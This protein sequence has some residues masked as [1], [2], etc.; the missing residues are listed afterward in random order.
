MYDLAWMAD[1]SA[2]LGLLT[3]VVMEIVLG[4]DNLVFIAILASK[5]PVKLQAKAR[6]TGLGMALIIRLCLLSVISWIVTLT[7]PL[8]TIGEFNLSVRDLIMLGGGAFLLYK[9]THELHEKLEG[10][11][12]NASASSK[13]T[14]HAFWL[15][16]SQ[17]VVLDAVF[18]LD[19]VI[20]AVGMTEH[21]LI[22]MFAVVIAM[23]LM[24]IASKPLTEFVSGRPTLIILCLSFLLMIGFSL[25]ADGLHLHVP[26]AYLYAA[27]GFSIL[28]EIFN[29]IARKNSLRLAKNTKDSRELAASLVLRILGSKSDNQFQTIKE[30]IVSPP[31]DAVFASEEKD[32]VSRALQLS[33]QPIRAVMTARPDVEMVDITKPY[34]EICKVLASS[35]FSHVVAY[36]D[37]NRDAPV[38]IINKTEVFNQMVQNGADKQVNITE[39][40]RTPLYVPETISVLKALEEA[41]TAK[42]YTLFVVDEFGNYEGLA[43]LH[44]ILEEIAGELPEMTEIS[45]CIEREDG[46]FYVQADLA[47]TE[48]ARRTGLNIEPT[49]HYHTLAGYIIETSQIVPPENSQLKVDNFTLTIAKVSNHTIHAVIV[50]PDPNKKEV[51]QD[52]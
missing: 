22:M 52:E 23:S 24:V 42:N 31:T 25:L 38:G 18:S 21:V 47:L 5:L 44:D 19:S 32:L 48:L 46:S 26:K 34:E 45:D 2:W 12:P 41:R 15:V 27:I 13:A 33:G 9:S 8:C 7:N 49:V 6:Y 35:A 17:I 14:T 10:Q 36:R 20:T 50:T 29:Q 16:V 43:T 40:V 39:L 3:L 4:I 37:G 30:S 28:I 11:D 1:P 51:E